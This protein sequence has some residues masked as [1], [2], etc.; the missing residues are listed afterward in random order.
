MAQYNLCGV[1]CDRRIVFSLFHWSDLA[2]SVTQKPLD[3]AGAD[4]GVGFTIPKSRQLKGAMALMS[5]WHLSPN[6]ITTEPLL[7]QH[8]IKWNLGQSLWFVTLQFAPFLW[9]LSNMITSILFCILGRI[10]FA[11]QVLFLSLF[12]FSLSPPL[13]S[14][15]SRW[16]AI[17]LVGWPCQWKAPLLG[18]ISSGHSAVCLWI[19]RKLSGYEIFLQLWRR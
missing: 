11:Y 3:T 12:L 18:R 8:S 7:S 6:G 5:N 15:S 14:L 17:C 13:F 2:P 16:N 9:I 1:S 10:Q 4:T 19:G